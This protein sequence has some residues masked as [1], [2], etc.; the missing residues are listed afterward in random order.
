MVAIGC[1]AWL[2]LRLRSRFATQ[3]ADSSS[4]WEVVL[5]TKTMTALATGEGNELSA[6]TSYNSRAG[7]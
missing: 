2:E 7:T 4:S 3:R 5:A 1:W 6:T